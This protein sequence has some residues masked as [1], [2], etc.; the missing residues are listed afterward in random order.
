MVLRMLTRFMLARKFVSDNEM[1]LQH[2]IKAGIRPAFLINFISEKICFLYQLIGV[3]PSITIFQL[4]SP[5]SSSEAN[6]SFLV[7]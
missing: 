2:K 7:T 5:Y 6:A 4:P 1:G 3:M